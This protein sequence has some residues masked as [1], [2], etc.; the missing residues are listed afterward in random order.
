MKKETIFEIVMET[1][2]FFSMM[3]T[4]VAMVA[5]GSLIVS[6]SSFAIGW[7]FYFASVVSKDARKRHY[8]AMNVDILDSDLCQ[9][10]STN[11]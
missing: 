8:D 3:T 5:Y 6:V 9:T 11:I 1:L 7:T 4:L 10:T 2:A